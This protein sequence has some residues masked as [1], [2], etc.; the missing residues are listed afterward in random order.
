MRERERARAYLVPI[1]GDE[2]GDP[3]L[4]RVQVAHQTDLLSV[5]GF[6]VVQQVTK[7]VTVARLI[8]YWRPDLSRYKTPIAPVSVQRRID[9]H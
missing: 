4:K 8:L 9:G 7:L 2:L 6:G 3:F 1:S 5:S